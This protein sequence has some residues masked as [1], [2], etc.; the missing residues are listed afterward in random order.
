MVPQLQIMIL[1][2]KHLVHLNS[3]GTAIRLDNWNSTSNV[4]DIEAH[5]GFSEHRY[6]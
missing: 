1:K 6:R 3:S 4:V 5:V 2:F